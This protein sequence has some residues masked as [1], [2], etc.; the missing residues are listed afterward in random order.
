MCLCQLETEV[1]CILC[2]G[3]FFEFC[4]NV[5]RGPFS[6]WA[7]FGVNRQF[8]TVYGTIKRDLKIE[9]LDHVPVGVKLCLWPTLIRIWLT[10]EQW[11]LCDRPQNTMCL[12][13]LCWSGYTWYIFLSSSP[14]L[15]L[16]LHVNGKLGPFNPQALSPQT[17]SIVV[18]WINLIWNSIIRHLITRSGSHAIASVLLELF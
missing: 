8:Q 7:Q 12:S 1:N 2:I 16:M 18:W 11:N 14:L 5:G 15:L 6:Q 3:T 10:A 9:N 13:G 17:G 4:E